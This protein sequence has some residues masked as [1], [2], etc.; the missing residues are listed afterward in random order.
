MTLEQKL[1]IYDLLVINY[2]V[3]QREKLSVIGHYLSQHGVTASNCGCAKL[4]DVFDQM[5][6][7]CTIDIVYPETGAPPISYLTV[8]PRPNMDEMVEDG[9]VAGV[10]ET[11]FSDLP[12]N[13]EEDTV[14]FDY[15]KQY[16]LT[17]YVTGIPQKRLTDEQ[18]DQ[19]KQD[20][21]TE[22]EAGRIRY[23]AEHNCYTFSLTLAAK[24]GT[25]LMLSIMKDTRGGRCPWRV[26]FVGI[27]YVKAGKTVRPGEALR[28][29]AY[30]G[31]Q[32]EFLRTLAEYVQEETWNFSG[33]ADDYYILNQYITYTF[34]RVESE[35]KIGYSEDG[36]FAAFN[37]GLQS[38]RLGEDVFAFFERNS[39]GE[40]SPW[41]FRCFCSQDSRDE[42]F[43]YKRMIDAFGEPEP[44]SYFNKITDLLFDPAGEVRLSSDHIFKDNCDRLPMDFLEEKTFRYPEARALLGQIKAA[45][46][47][48]RK[49]LY[50][51]LGTLITEDPDL[52]SSMNESLEG[53][54]RR[55]LKRIRRNYKL[56]VPCFF[57]TRNKMSMMLPISFTA[58]GEPELVLV[59]ERTNSGDYLGQTILTLAMAYVDARL[60]C[61]PGSEWL[62]TKNIIT[63]DQAEITTEE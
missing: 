48:E 36:T 33:K 18:Y 47:A 2:E 55:T 1:H 30:L 46:A 60:L 39:E 12:E 61:Q 24:D 4:Q 32:T 45:P 19:V 54:L 17:R 59:C 9:V 21:L 53:A 16:D 5:T 29:F 43:Y 26:H 50:E 37:T 58:T 44:A 31:N 15:Y 7:F 3:G 41:N 42:R 40:G 49:A 22:K 25:P 10:Q 51:Q 62:N 14:F 28:R 23:D 35:K 8:L 11:L 38:R 34:Y 6:E 63:S 27:D 52:I 56:A 13:M 20:Y 57:P